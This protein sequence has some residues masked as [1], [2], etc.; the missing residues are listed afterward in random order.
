MTSIRQAAEEYLA[1][2]RALGFKLAIQ[3]RCLLGFV[4]YLEQAKA[5]RITTELALA[6]ATEPSNATMSWSSRRLGIVRRFAQYLQALDPTT[7]VPPEDLLPERTVR[8]AAHIYTDGQLTAVLHEAGQLQPALRAVT[9]RT[10]I[11]LL[12]V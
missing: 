12:A 1:L 3:G 8:A 9:W 10:L 2:R 11:G 6:W 5:T 7:D 4:E